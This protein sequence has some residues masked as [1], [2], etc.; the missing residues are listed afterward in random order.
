[1]LLLHIHREALGAGQLLAGRDFH[2]LV[3][4]HTIQLHVGLHHGVL[5]EHAVLDHSTL[6]DLDAAEQ[7]TVLYG[8]LNEAAVGQ[9]GV[10]HLGAGDITGGVVVT[11]LRVDRAALRQAM[12]LNFSQ[13]RILTAA[14]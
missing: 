14:L 4:D 1:M 3:G 12:Q 10:F 2:V 11:D 5:H 9:D 8:A 7:H 13:N 6:L